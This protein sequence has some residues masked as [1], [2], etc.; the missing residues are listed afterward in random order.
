VASE[1]SVP[2]ERELDAVTARQ[3]GRELA[4]SIGFSSTDQTLLATAI[5][6][7]AR[8]IISYAGHGKI[9]LTT[10]VEGGR[11]GIM[12][13][14]EDQ[15]PGISDP[16]LAMRDGFSTGKSL[17]L[18]LPGARRLVDEFNL[19]TALGQGTKVTLKKWLP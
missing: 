5:S 18:G 10:V 11:R 7:L 13:V 15:G 19:E 3:K 1:A 17:G 6:E 14:A 9:E 8:N 4:A 16:E 2:I 12:I